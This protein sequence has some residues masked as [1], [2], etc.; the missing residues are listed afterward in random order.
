MRVHAASGYSIA[1]LAVTV[2][3]VATVAAIAVPAVE[4]GLDEARTAGAARYLSARLADARMEAIQRST[5]VAM[6][7]NIT[8]RGYTYAVYGRQSDGCWR[9]TSRGLDR[10][11]AEKRPLQ[12]LS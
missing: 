7:F 12:S 4:A 3:V 5:E 6:R 9:A 1:E 8:G 11:S 10:R 2:G